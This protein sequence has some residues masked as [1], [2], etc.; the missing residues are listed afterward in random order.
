MPESSNQDKMYQNLRNFSEMALPQ[1][2]LFCETFNSTNKQELVMECF[3]VDN[4]IHVRVSS[5]GASLEPL[6]AQFRIFIADQVMKL[7]KELNFNVKFS[8][9]YNFIDIPQDQVTTL[10]Y[11][12]EPRLESRGNKS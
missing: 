5:L 6:P 2:K 8:R 10:V 11:V 12:L 9:K 3:I 4:V 7:G 1:A